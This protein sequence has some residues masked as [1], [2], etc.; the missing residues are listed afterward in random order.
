MFSVN[1]Y[2]HQRS[3]EGIKF[4]ALM[5]VFISL[6]GFTQFENKH[7]KSEMPGNQQKGASANMESR[8]F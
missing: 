4:M 1:K 6:F 7:F 8:N 2:E 3:H 5:F